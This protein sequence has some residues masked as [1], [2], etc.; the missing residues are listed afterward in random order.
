MDGGE[1]R[2]VLFLLAEVIFPPDSTGKRMKAVCMDEWMR[3]SA[4]WL[5]RRKKKKGRPM[6]T[7]HVC[8]LL[9]M[10]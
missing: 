6:R 10:F 8:Q 7:F 9:E 1:Q 3:I 5:G 4:G 2:G